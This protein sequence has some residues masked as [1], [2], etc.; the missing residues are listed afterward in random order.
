HVY[1]RLFR[2]FDEVLPLALDEKEAKRIVRDEELLYNMVEASAE[3]VNDD[4][5][6]KSMLRTVLKVGRGEDG[7]GGGGGV[8]STAIG[9]EF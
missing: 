6:N 4:S 9:A 3:S 1:D 8:S 7:G 2:G 5:F